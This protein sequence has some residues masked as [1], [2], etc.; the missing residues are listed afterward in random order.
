MLP[1]SL[2]EAIE[3]GEVFTRGWVVELLLDLVGYVPER[4]LARLV[5]AEPA[6]G[7]GAFLGPI[8]RRLGESC[9]RHGRGL[10]DALGSVVAY[11]LLESNVEHSRVLVHQEL[12]AQGWDADEARR[13]AQHWVGQGDYLLAR[14]TASGADVVVGN[15]PYIRLEDVPAARMAAY[16]SAHPTMGG[17]ADVYVG[18]YEAALRSLNPG[19]VLGF[20]CADRWMHNQYG[21]RLRELVGREYSV[22]VVLSM[23]DV[24]AFEEQVAAY[25]AITVLSSRPQGE[26]VAAEATRSFTPQDAA[27]LVEWCRAGGGGLERW[28]VRAVRLPHWFS[29]GDFWPAASPA[30]LALLE[31]LTDR[32]PTLEDPH[33]ATR[34]SIGVATGADKVF[35]TTDPDI[36]EPECL[37][38][39]AMV[40]DIASGTFTWQGHYLI[41]PWTPAGNLVC[42]DDLP[43]LRRYLTAHAAVLRRRYVAVKQPERWYKTIDKVDHSLIGRSKLLLPD[44]KTTIHPVLDEGGF[45]PH[46]NLYYITSQDWDLRVLGGLLISGIAEAFVHAYGVKMRGGTLRFQAQYLRKIRVPH[47]GRIGDK[48]QAALSKAFERRD[49]AVAT[50]AALDAYGLDHLPD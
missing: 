8:S 24:D 7:R 43:R 12:A 47:P 13:C 33:G 17:R 3:H 14:P 45:Y 22:D 6:C 30:R 29:G 42:L 9:R 50:E 4:D 19:G 10:E 49:V 5:I 28:G 26:V 21:A 48:V 37:L 25:P 1:P 41:N 39:L 34:V 35:I 2:Q 44:M 31:D 27:Q 15:P 16:R 38:P 23:H 36:V 40:R 11:D 32:F 18:F 46:H 20:I